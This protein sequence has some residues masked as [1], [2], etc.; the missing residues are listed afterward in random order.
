MK[1][2][3][4]I[5]KQFC[6]RN[7]KTLAVTALFGIATAASF[8]IGYY[9]GD[10]EF[11]TTLDGETIAYDKD[12]LLAGERRYCGAALELL[13]KFYGNDDNEFWFEVVQNLPEYKAMEEANG[14]DWEDFYY[15]Q[16]LPLNAEN[17]RAINGEVQ[18]IDE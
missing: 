11:Y 15:W 5:V 1:K 4:K 3:F 12:Q 2:I 8:H 14:G 10:N 9:L 6:A 7:A 17:Y 16:E 18:V 13:H